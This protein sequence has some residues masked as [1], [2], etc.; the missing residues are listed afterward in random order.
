MIAILDNHLTVKIISLGV[1]TATVDFVG[2]VLEVSVD[3][4]TLEK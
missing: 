1:T 3:R 4:L 2:N